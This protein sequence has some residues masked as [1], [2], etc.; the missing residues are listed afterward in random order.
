MKKIG[1]IFT[2]YK[3]NYKNKDGG[4]EFYAGKTEEGRNIIAFINKSKKGSDYLSVY[5][6]EEGKYNTPLTGGRIHSGQIMEQK[7]DNR[8]D[9]IDP[10]DLPF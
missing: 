10:N 4:G 5:I 6:D 9:I 2:Q 1:V 7:P 3:K 8:E